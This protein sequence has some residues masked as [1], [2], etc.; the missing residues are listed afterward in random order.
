MDIDLHGVTLRFLDA[1]PGDIRLVQRQLPGVA[2]HAGVVD[3]DVVVAFVDTVEMHGEVRRIG[4]DLVDDKGVVLVRPGHGRTARARLTLGVGG[5]GV[6]VC[7]RHVREVPLLVT[8]VRL[9]ALGKGLLALHAVAFTHRGIGVAA[10]G[11][12]GSGKT[13]VLL[14]MNAVGAQ[15]VAAEWVLVSQDGSRLLGVPQAVR[16]K[17]SHV[18]R[19]ADL[20]RL[21]RA[22]GGTRGR[23]LAALRPMMA[24]VAPPVKARFDRALHVDVPL[25]RFETGARGAEVTGRLPT[26]PF[27]V[28]V[29]LEDAEV[30]EPTVERVEAGFA[31]ERIAVGL[32]HDLAEFYAARRVLHYASARSC[33]DSVGVAD[34]AHRR[35]LARHLASRP[36]FLLRHRQPTSF[37]ALQAAVEQAIT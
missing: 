30:G 18:D 2:P 7:E 22:V 4:D 36:V 23:L 9:A 26:A 32:E 24:R 28:L 35:L 33:E 25:H 6:V 17:P 34:D 19:C 21:T 20:A 29:L 3:P 12:S 10:T 27:D 14:A 11:W 13:A 15:P 37:A 31:T 8:L 5:E 16:L 1:H